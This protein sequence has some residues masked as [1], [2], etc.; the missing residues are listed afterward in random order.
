MRKLLQH[1]GF[2]GQVE[3]ASA[4][5]EGWHVGEAPDPR[6]C[7]HALRR[8]YDIA[9]QR[10]RQLDPEDFERFDWLVAMDYGHWQW[11]SEQCP[12][13]YRYKLRRA[14]DFGRVYPED[15]PDP[16][17]GGELEFEQVLDRVED[18]C[19]GIVRMLLEDSR[20]TSHARGDSHP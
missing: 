4:G 3:V 13:G 20:V 15:V 6:S 16:Y 17:D 2:D 7:D 18:V 9:G 10:A 14:R 8:G 5:I 12:P 1:R 19:A 11:L